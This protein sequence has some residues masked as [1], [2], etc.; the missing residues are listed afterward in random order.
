[1]TQAGIARNEYMLWSAHYTNTAHI[2]SPSACGY[3]QADATQWT[4]TYQGVSL[5][6]SLCYGYF[7]A[8]YPA[9]PPISV[10]R[11]MIV[12]DPE[13]NAYLLS[14]GRL[15]KI[16]TADDLHIYLDG[17]VQNVNAG[18]LSAAEFTALQA[19]FPAGQPDIS[20]TVPAIKFPT[21]T[22]TPA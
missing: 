7:F 16:Q 20:A 19:D 6:A 15:H 8:T 22:V 13:N 17:G 1:M 21:F 3:P 18:R 4:S 11:E 5:D 12:Y 14:G 10:E 9:D 2:C